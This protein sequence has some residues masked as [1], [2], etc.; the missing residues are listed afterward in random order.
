[1]LGLSNF[2]SSGSQE[3]TIY[4]C[5]VCCNETHTSRAVQDVSFLT[6]RQWSGPLCLYDAA[7]IL[8][9]LK[10]SSNLVW[11][12]Q[13]FLLY[14]VGFLVILGSQFYHFSKQILCTIFKI[15]IWLF[16][17]RVPLFSLLVTGYSDNLQ[18]SNEVQLSCDIGMVF[19]E[20]SEIVFEFHM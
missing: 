18:I 17:Y 7:V 5:F 20:S 1:M 10:A 15:N 13:I 3:L 6:E 14:L 9:N 4:W 19:D 8:L 16:S 12:E 11:C 2:S